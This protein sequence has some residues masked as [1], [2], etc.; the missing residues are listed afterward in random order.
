MISRILGTLALIIYAFVVPVM[1]LNSTHLFNP[2][3]VPHARTHE[4]WQLIT[5]TSFGVL[6]LWLIWKRDNPQL[7]GVISTIIMGSFLIAFLLQDSY[8]GSM[9]ISSTQPQKTI[10]GIGLGVL[11]ASLSFSL[12]IASVIFARLQKRPRATSH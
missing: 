4:A 12:A 2:D 11:G 10:L 5:N 1:E 7:A 9:A 8:G 3:W 6:A